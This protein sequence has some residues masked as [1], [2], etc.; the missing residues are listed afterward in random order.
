MEELIRKAMRS[1]LINSKEEAQEAIEFVSELLN[2]QIKE[3][4]EKEPHMKNWIA[5]AEEA[6]R[7]VDNLSEFVDENLPA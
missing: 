5:R 4:I 6:L 7:L 1:S 2:L 3:T